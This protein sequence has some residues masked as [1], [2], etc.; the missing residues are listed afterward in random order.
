ML[1]DES[2]KFD[3]FANLSDIHPP[4]AELPDSYEKILDSEIITMRKAE[5]LESLSASI[6]VQTI[7]ELLDKIYKVRSVG[8]TVYSHGDI[9]VFNDKIV[10]Q[11]VYEVN[12]IFSILID[13]A[14]NYIDTSIGNKVSS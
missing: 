1:L 4:D 10:Y 14:G 7:N 9:K 5:F 13:R 6:N 12:A 11:L 2:G 8:K 3:G